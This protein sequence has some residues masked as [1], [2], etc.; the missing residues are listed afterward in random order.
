M[1]SAQTR[2]CTVLQCATMSGYACVPCNNGFRAGITCLACSSPCQACLGGA[3]GARPAT[4]ATH[5][6][7]CQRAPF[8][9]AA[10]RAERRAS[11]AAAGVIAHGPWLP[12]VHLALHRHRRVCAAGDPGSTLWRAHALVSGG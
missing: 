2:K 6:R 1:Q 12:T 8:R 9:I 7:C 3:G 10:G 4:P 5:F 11:S